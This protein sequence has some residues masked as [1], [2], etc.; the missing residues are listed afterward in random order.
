LWIVRG[1]RHQDADAP[2]AFGLLRTH[3]ERPS[4]CSTAEQADELAPPHAEHGAPS[5]GAAADHTS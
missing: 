4:H 3:R 2:N 1:E 5:P